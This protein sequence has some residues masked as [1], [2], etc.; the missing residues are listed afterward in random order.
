MTLS[1]CCPR[2][3]ALSADVLV[4]PT[5]RDREITYQNAWGKGIVLLPH[6]GIHRTD[7]RKALCLKCDYV[8]VV[9]G[10]EGFLRKLKYHHGPPPCRGCP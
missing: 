5:Q 2:C 8:G 10:P 6:Q 7:A 1:Y 4:L 3:G 9:N